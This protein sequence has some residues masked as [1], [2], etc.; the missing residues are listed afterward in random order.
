MDAK[1]VLLDLETCPNL[2]E[3]V[4]VFPGLSNYPGLTLKATI[5]TII[6]FGYKVLGEKQAHVLNSWELSKNISNDKALCKKAFDI[7]SDADCIV[8][9]NGKRF[10]WRFLQTRLLVNNLPPLPSKILHV[11]TCAVARAKL[12][13]F[14]NKL[15]TLA[16]MTSEKK[17]ENGGWELWVKVLNGDKAARKLM[18]AY[19]KQDI[20]TLE[21]VFK[22]L[23]P[24]IDNLPNQ[25]L[26]SEGGK[27]VCPNCGS[28]R[29]L[30]NGLRVTS[31]R[32]YRRYRCTDCHSSCNTD[33][34]DKNPRAI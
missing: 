33:V 16:E 13:T 24:L 31:T 19:C 6:C 14:N 20:I 26:F 27:P 21:A 10:D 23:R 17:L 2:S 11:D 34:N 22:K 9:H 29:L 30:S 1:I 25:N 5:N 32:K 12:L 3:V 18:S 15:N 28:T 8:T 4:K 7:L